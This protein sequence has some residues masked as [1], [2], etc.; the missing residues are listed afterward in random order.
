MRLKCKGGGKIQEQRT[1]F[2]LVTCFISV[3][4]ELVSHQGSSVGLDD[5]YRS[6]PTE[7]V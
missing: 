2:N 3:N 5:H 4:P 6:L 1:C 7:T